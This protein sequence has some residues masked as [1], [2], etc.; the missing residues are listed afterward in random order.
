M[1]NEIVISI[2][3]SIGDAPSDFT[4]LCQIWEQ[5]QGHDLDVMLDFSQ[6]NFLRPNAIAFF[7]GMVRLVQARGGRVKT[8]GSQISE[9]LRSYLWYSEFLPTFLPQQYPTI[10]WPTVV[11][12]REHREL[13]PLVIR[14]YLTEKW[15]K[16]EWIDASPRLR[17]VIIEHVSEIYTNA[18]EH[19]QSPIG[20]LS[21][22]QYYPKLKQLALCVVDFGQGVATNVRRFLKNDTMEVTDVLKWA[23][24][25]SM[26]T[27]MDQGISRGMGLHLLKN[28]VQMNK[29]TLQI[30]SNDGRVLIDEKKEVYEDFSP[31][32]R[33][34]IVQINLQ[35][36]GRY[37]VLPSEVDEEDDNDL[38]SGG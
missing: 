36:D 34:T 13:D 7:G 20:V 12:F 25:E 17:Q 8:T 5:V 30:Y 32:F 2:P 4:K 18:F 23:F 6:T 1:S 22:G 33:G 35:C 14:K 16:Q 3:W 19:A 37:Y 9:R 10:Q 21:C 24:S 11:P 28:F 26:S 31:A 15:L 38:F 27:K 29:G